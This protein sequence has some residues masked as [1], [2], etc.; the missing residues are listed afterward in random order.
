MHWSQLL[1]PVVSGLVVALIIGMVKGLRARR[2]IPNAAKQKVNRHNYLKAIHQA[3]S[4]PEVKQL[5]AV[6]PWLA[7]AR[8]NPQLARIQ[9]S[10]EA[11]G[12]VR[13]IT[14]E[15]EGCL[16]AGAELLS[17]GVEVRVGRS[18]NTDGMSFHIY[19]GSKPSVVVNRRDGKRD[20]PL[21][22]DGQS[23]TQVFQSHFD[24]AWQNS[25][26]LEAVLAEQALRPGDGVVAAVARI[27]DVR[28]KY[29]LDEKATAALTRHV[30]F[31]HS[32][33]V[34]FV[35]GL[36]GA[37]KSMVRRLLAE[38]LRAQRFQVD[39]LTDYLYAY[40]DHVHRL[41]ALGGTRGE[42]FTAHA[43]GAFNVRDERDLEP[44]LQALS[45]RVWQSRDR[46]RITLVEFARA[47]L[48]AALEVFGDEVLSVAQIIHVTASDETR[49]ARLDH[50]K[51]PP[52][53]SIVGGDIVISPSDDHE[54]P[55]TA[56]RSLYAVDGLTALKTMPALRDR[57]HHLDN[58]TGHD[59]I[60]RALDGFIESVVRPYQAAVTV[61]A[62]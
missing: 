33:P 15:D 57:V 47:D 9:E 52:K 10:W 18:L 60:E 27:D 29:G 37:G 19:R 4:A 31:R 34:V 11:I 1:T 23:E 32:A 7:P 2:R 56:A 45:L 51:Q 35:T 55:S 14:R 39:E 62:A 20:H 21:Q 38:K 40:H 17:R 49:A 61:N 5:R 59:W 25:V 42:G 36:P 28:V 54:L 46:T 43:G 44:A 41:I 30:A 6:V 24:V 12:D 8:D 26:P 48:A 13:L 58:D 50:R 53:L 16:T 22:L 3:S